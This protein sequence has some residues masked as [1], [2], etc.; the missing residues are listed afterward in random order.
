MVDCEEDGAC[1]ERVDPVMGWR[2]GVLRASVVL[3]V[4]CG[5]K[6]GEAERG[7]AEIEVGFG[8]GWRGEGE[9]LSSAR[10]G[11]ESVAR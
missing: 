5:V 2:G 6:S 11:C 3:I 10:G 8:T 4:Y 7:D 1:K 9:L